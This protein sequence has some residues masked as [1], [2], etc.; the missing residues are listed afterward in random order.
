[1]EENK[2]TATVTAFNGVY[3]RAVDKNGTPY[4]IH[5]NR[6]VPEHKDRMR[7]DLRKGCTIRFGDTKPTG[8]IDRAIDIEPLHVP[9]W[10]EPTGL[11]YG[12]WDVTRGIRC[13][14]CGY[15]SEHAHAYCPSCGAVMTGTCCGLEPEKPVPGTPVPAARVRPAEAEWLA[16]CRLLGL[17]PDSVYGHVTVDNPKREGGAQ[18]AGK[19]QDTV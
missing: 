9:E 17:D 18:D 6:F 4:K 15:K 10:P 3:G 14:A 12:K 5:V 8:T 16:A 2:T 13:T 7:R 19:D 1:M 11:P